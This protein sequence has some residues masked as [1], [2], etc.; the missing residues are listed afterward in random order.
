LVIE[1]QPQRARTKLLA[2]ALIALAAMFSFTS[3]S[4]ARPFRFVTHPK[5]LVDY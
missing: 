4:E 1:E 2:G 3:N 5:G